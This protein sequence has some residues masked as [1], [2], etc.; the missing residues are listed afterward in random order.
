MSANFEQLLDENLSKVNLKPGSLVTG[1]VIDILETHVVFHLG[2]KSEG[3]IPINEFY[4]E[5][6]NPL[7][8][9]H[10]IYDKAKKNPVKGEIL[11]IDNE[12]VS[13]VISIK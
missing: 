1:I 11:S 10:E 9:I 12:K 4:D 2:L 8:D 6:G 5:S 13:I 7:F 3:L